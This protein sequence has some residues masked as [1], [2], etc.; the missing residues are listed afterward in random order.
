VRLRED[1]V[2]AVRLFRRQPAIVGMTIA[3]LALAIGI[4]TAA[5]TIIDLTVAP[6]HGVPAPHRV[7]SLRSVAGTAGDDGMPLQHADYLA[8]REIASAA[9]VTA[10]FWS[11]TGS[12]VRLG[13]AEAEQTFRSGQFAVVSGNYFTVIGGKAATGRTLSDSDD[14][15]GAP[16]TVVLRHAFWTR[17]F[18]GDVSV[19]GRTIWFNDEPATVVGVAEPTFRGTCDGEMGWTSLPAFLQRNRISQA[20]LLKPG[21][22][23]RPLFDLVRVF[24]RPRG[25]ETLQSIEPAIN[26]LATRIFTKDGSVDARGRTPIRLRPIDELNQS[27]RTRLLASG[28][29]I[30]LLLLI[31]CANVTNLLLASATG[32]IREIG[33]RL[34]LGARRGQIVRMLLTESLL[35]GVVGA[36]AGLVI[37]LWATPTLAH[38]MGEQAAQDDLAPSLRVLGF[39]V[40]VAIGASALAG[41]APA[42]RSARLDLTSAVKSDLSGRPRGLSGSRLRSTLIA[43]QSAIAVVLLILA[44]LATRVVVKASGAEL[45]ADVPRLVN[46]TI[47]FKDVDDD[48]R[49]FFVDVAKTRLRELTGVD[50]ATRVVFPLFGHGGAHGRLVSGGSVNFNYADAD[51]FATAGIRLVGGRTFSLDEVRT[52]A[53][54]A[55][56][57]ESLAK[58]YWSDGNPIG[59]SMERLW[60][61]DDREGASLTSWNRKP[62]GTRIIGVVAETWADLLD[63]SRPVIYLPLH[64]GTEQRESLV[65]RAG[66][67]TDPDSLHALIRD[68]LKSLDSRVSITVESADAN[69]RAQLAYPVSRAMLGGLLGFTA[70]ALALVGLFGVTAFSVAQRRHEVAVRLAIGASRGGILRMLIGAS[71]RPVIAGV[72]GG[73]LFSKPVLDVLQAVIGHQGRI[74]DVAPYDGY[75]LGGAVLGMCIAAIAAAAAPARHAMNVDAAEVLKQA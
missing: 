23:A 60:G 8:L 69:R 73:L 39:M 5:F 67:A 13:A 16:S 71:M 51:Y 29:L 9:D 12:T 63:R 74:F 72:G 64:P 45:G 58:T 65:V 46:V 66:P 49:R 48:S 7:A 43:V 25:D 56:I 6:R 27:E 55:V 4:S 28:V 47:Q 59:D 75:A 68:A 37:A 33:T 44:G 1:V 36:A 31:A 22:P 38:L 2:Y 70:L 3:G 61:A 57:S 52:T 19:L 14:A 17:Q 41:L 18:G 26:A 62:A 30:A 32:R 40:L 24:V 10:C 11:S 35:L 20:R 42:R 50:N 53:R 34:A 54:V 21:E 15:P